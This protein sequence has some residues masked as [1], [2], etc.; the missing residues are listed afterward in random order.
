LRLRRQAGSRGRATALVPRAR[1]TPENLFDKLFNAL[2]YDAKV[3]LDAADPHQQYP[4]E[5]NRNH[6][7]CGVYVDDPAGHH[8]EITRR[9]YS[10]GTVDCAVDELTSASQ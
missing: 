6:G 1:S 4:G 2:C 5:I 3:S 10:S 7:G 9:R 8:L